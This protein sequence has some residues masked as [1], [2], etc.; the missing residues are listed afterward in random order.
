MSQPPFIHTFLK[1]NITSVKNRSIHIFQQKLINIMKK[2]IYI[3]I[4]ACACFPFFGSQ[5]DPELVLGLE[6][7]QIQTNYAK[8]YTY[9]FLFC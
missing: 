4:Y 3:Y 7:I 9:L 8:F 5:M 2:S 6:L 1:S